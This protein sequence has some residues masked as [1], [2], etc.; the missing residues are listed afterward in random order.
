MN[1]PVDNK[2][3]KDAAKKARDGRNIALALG[4]AV[5]VVLVFVVTL[6]R[7]GGNVAHPH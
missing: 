7:L 3:A 1:Q 4:L 6:V 5:F 2:A